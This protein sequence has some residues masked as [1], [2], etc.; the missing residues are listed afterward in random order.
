MLNEI[1]DMIRRNV[2]DGECNLEY[3][4]F[5]ALL[6]EDTKGRL[7]LCSLTFKR[8]DRLSLRTVAYWAGF[9]G[10]SNHREIL[11]ALQNRTKLNPIVKTV[12]NC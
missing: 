2:G 6:D 10:G 9:E 8:N 1:C 5:V 4:L 11:K 12:K 3:V 7:F